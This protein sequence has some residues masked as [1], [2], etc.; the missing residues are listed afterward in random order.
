M[1]DL[2]FLVWRDDVEMSAASLTRSLLVLPPGLF[3]SFALCG[4]DGDV[5]GYAWLRL[6]LGSRGGSV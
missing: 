3:P 2:K 6:E 1:A 5:E 4:D